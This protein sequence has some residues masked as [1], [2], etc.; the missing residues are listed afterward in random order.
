MTPVETLGL[1]KYRAQELGGTRMLTKGFNPGLSVKWD[2]MQGLRFESSEPDEED[3][4]SFLLTFRQFVS[5][6]EPVHLL[7]IYNVCREV[8]TSDELKGYLVQSRAVWKRALKNAG[9]D[10]TIDDVKMTPEHVA[11][12]WI[13]GVYFHNDD[14]NRRE[15]ERLVPYEKLHKFV[16]L[17]YLTEGTRQV[18]YTASVI[19]AA[20]DNGAIRA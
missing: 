2:R 9:I 12:L 18:M 15:I 5:P 13:N 11:D 4:R 14:D 16:F 1:F 10:L 20:F 6:K 19:A 3:L 17:D 8:L 7:H